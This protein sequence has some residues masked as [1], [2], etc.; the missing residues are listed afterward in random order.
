MGK[1]DHACDPEENIQALDELLQ[2]VKNM[3]VQKVIDAYQS[4]YAR[5][6]SR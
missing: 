4:A 3:G 1:H 5:Y 2:Q 6:Q